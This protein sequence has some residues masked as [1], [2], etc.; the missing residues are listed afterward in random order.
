MRYPVSAMPYN[1]LTFDFATDRNY[2]FVKH[3]KQSLT[4]VMQTTQPPFH[5]ELIQGN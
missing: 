3:T 1:G 5:L 4:F 2:S